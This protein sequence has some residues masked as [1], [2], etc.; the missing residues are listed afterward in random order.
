LTDVTPVNALSVWTYI[1]KQKLQQEIFLKLLSTGRDI[2][3]D[4][5]NKKTT[6]TLIR[7]L[8]F[9]DYSLLYR[10]L[11]PKANAFL[12]IKYK[13]FEK[14]AILDLYQKI[15]REE[16]SKEPD[17][18][19]V[20]IKAFELRFIIKNSL[21]NAERELN[22]DEKVFLSLMAPVIE[23]SDETDGTYFCSQ[24][25]S[26]EEMATALQRFRKNGKVRVLLVSLPPDSPRS[27][28]IFPIH[29]ESLAGDLRNQFGDLVDVEIIDMQNEISENTLLKKIMGQRTD[30][31]GLS[32]RTMERKYAE[33]IL[34]TLFS[35]S[36][37]ESSKPGIIVLG[38]H[39]PR[40]APW[41]F[42]RDYPETVIC[43]SEGEPALRGLVTEFLKG[44]EIQL[45]NIPNICYFSKYASIQINAISPHDFND[46]SIPSFDTIKDIREKNGVVFIE[47]G[48]GCPWNKCTFCNRRF[49]TGLPLGVR[50]VPVE[51]LLDELEILYKAGVSILSFTDLDFI[52]FDTERVE[53]IARG[54]LERGIKMKFWIQTRVDSIYIDGAREEQNNRKK[55]ALKLFKEAGLEKIFLGI[56]SGSPSQLQRYKKGI[57]I[58]STKEAVTVIRELGLKLEAGYIPLDP[59]VTI[60]ELKETLAFAEELKIVEDIAKLHVL[61]LERQDD[62][63]SRLC[64]NV[65]Y[66]GKLPARYLEREKD[67]FYRVYSEGLITGEK[68]PDTRLYPYRMKEPEVEEIKQTFLKWEKKTN[69]LI[70][71]LRRAVDSAFASSL[72]DKYLRLF[73]RM[74]FIVLKGLVNI[75]GGIYDP[76]SAAPGIE[77]DLRDFFT[78]PNLHEI[79]KID[80]SE[81]NAMEENLKKS[82]DLTGKQKMELINCLL[83]TASSGRDILIK[84]LTRD[85]AIG[86]IQD[87]ASKISNELL[88]L[89]TK[90]ELTPREKNLELQLVTADKL[91]LIYGS[92]YK[93]YKLLHEMGSIGISQDNL[94]FALTKKDLLIQLSSGSHI[95]LIINTTMEDM[96]D[97]LK[98]TTESIPVLNYVSTNKR[99]LKDA[100]FNF[101]ECS[102]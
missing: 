26:F 38:G 72:E 53:R 93:C 40:V 58:G 50:K 71:C 73:K 96:K 46:F 100:L 89:R 94:I 47:S 77:A 54:I 32:V 88:K 42:L 97:I 80:T 64:S 21:V 22:R 30:I 76:G 95:D 45:S 18:K 11:P 52:A 12:K 61:C 57:T 29:S 82:T 3:I 65:E 75:I 33:K 43:T 36:F 70:Y 17:I 49:S 1:E 16:Y 74:D 90:Q 79:C 15:S 56:E 101:F 13:I 27:S 41:D 19:N 6:I 102:A 5:A 85:L 81:L 37:P 28:V 4:P 99:R 51:T 25:F 10:L 9:E 62:L 14:P 23:A 35:N 39:R 98:E 48:R 83:G 63:I 59:F 44:G 55:A 34:D 87:P 69:S 66:I 31:L 78:C 86:K 2:T 68:D 24:F 67:L 7:E 92:Y 91:I 60:K 20:I 8:L 84:N